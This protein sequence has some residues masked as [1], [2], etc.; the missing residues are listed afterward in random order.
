MPQAFLSAAQGH[1]EQ[2]FRKTAID[3]LTLA[4]ALDLIIDTLKQIALTTESD[5]P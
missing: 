1:D 5:R 2:E 3:V 4:E